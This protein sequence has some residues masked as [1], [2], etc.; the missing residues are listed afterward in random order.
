MNREPVRLTGL[1]SSGRV[2]GEYWL[3]LASS[4]FTGHFTDSSTDSG[5][6][7]LPNPLPLTQQNL[8]ARV[9]IEPTDEAFA[10]PCLTTWLPR[11]LKQK[12]SLP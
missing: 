5:R 9:G 8:E 7:D 4:N 2:S 3:V 10:E 1:A 11:H 6:S 12:F